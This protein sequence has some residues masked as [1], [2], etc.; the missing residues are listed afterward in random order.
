MKNKAWGGRFKAAQTKAFLE[1]GASIGFDKKLAEYDVMQNVAHATALQKARILTPAELK[2]IVGGLKKVAA[3]IRAGKFKY[4]VEDEDIHMNIERRLTEI[5]GPLAGKVH[6]GRSRNDHVA[7]DVRLYTRENAIAIAGLIAGLRRAFVAQ[8]EKNV[9]AVMPS[10]T[11]MQQA[12][13]IR[14]AHWFMA[15]QEMFRRDEERFHLAAQGANVMPLGSGALAGVNYPIDRRVTANLLGFGAISANSL[16]AVSDRDFAV[17]F[18]TAVAL[19]FAH[20]SRFAE[21]L[22][23]Y[24]SSEFGC[25]DLPDEYCTGSSIMPQKK[26]PDLLELFRGKTGRVNGNLISLLTIIKGLPLAYNKDLQ[27]DKIGLFDSCEQTLAALP[28]A[29]D[30]VKKMKFRVK[31]LEA[32]VKNG[33]LTAVDLA[34]YLALRGMPFREAHHVVGA[35]VRE[36]EEK[37]MTFADMTLKHLQAHSALFKKD[38]FD[39]LDPTKSPDR[40]KTFGSTAKKEILEQ[41]HAAKHELDK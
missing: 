25:I 17:E 24:S 32:R 23:I 2:K 7:T 4:R 3:E 36:C 18:L 27:E 8:A 31:L 22:I 6:T 29:T 21:D 41:I 12:Q 16:D 10:Y 26:N 11:H 28:L 38:V 40:K 14:V 30:F 37:G 33:F 39:Y 1:Y 13:P 35:I 19:L 9:D 5:I 20:L 34:D 15:Y